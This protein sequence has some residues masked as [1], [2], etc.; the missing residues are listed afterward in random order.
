[1][2]CGAAGNVPADMSEN[3]KPILPIFETEELNL[4]MPKAEELNLSMPKAEKL[5]L[6]ND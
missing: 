5:N 1:M 6:P 3:M 2:R 4:S